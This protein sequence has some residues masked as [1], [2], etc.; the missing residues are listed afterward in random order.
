MT[1]IPHRAIALL[2]AVSLVFLAGCG[3]APTDS[4]APVSDEPTTS[5]TT[6][7]VATTATPSATVTDST[8]GAATV[9]TEST[10]TTTASVP[11]TKPPLQGIA[12]T[13]GQQVRIQQVGQATGGHSEKISGWQL[14]RNQ[15]ELT[16]ANLAALKGHMNNPG[17]DV[18]AYTGDFFTDKALLLLY[19]SLPS[20]SIRIT[21][22]TLTVDGDTL[23]VHYTRTHPAALTADMAYW[24][25][26]VEVAKADTNRIEQVIGNE[27]IITMPSGVPGQ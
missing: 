19:F 4:S 15:D 18:S 23:T 6:T 5:N 24:C 25:V 26:L 11:P 13:V 27:T 2:L 22:D 7:T 16:T 3:A 9:T 14:L 21:V 1:K 10:A 8:P 20:G 12:F 17:V